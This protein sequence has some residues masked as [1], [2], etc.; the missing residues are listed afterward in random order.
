MAKT[1]AKTMEECIRTVEKQIELAL[2][3][4]EAVVSICSSDLVRNSITEEEIREML[5]EIGAATEALEDLY[6]QLD[7][8]RAEAL[9]M[10][11]ALQ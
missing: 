6:E 10:K 1:M 4:Y 3:G 5:R 8:M 9:M 2:G 11:E 7:D